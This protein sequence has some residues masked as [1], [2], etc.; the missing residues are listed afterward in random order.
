[1][2]HQLWSL[3]LAFVLAIGLL[4]DVPSTQDFGT[5]HMPVPAAASDS[6]DSVDSPLAIVAL[7][8][9]ASSRVITIK[10]PSASKPTAPTC[11]LVAAHSSMLERDRQASRDH[12]SMIRIPLRC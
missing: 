6:L 1:M 7:T 2:H 5:Q 12:S 8:R 3:S 4:A 10:H 9:G 11:Q